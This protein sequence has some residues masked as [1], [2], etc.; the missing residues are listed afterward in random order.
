MMLFICA[1]IIFASIF[2]Q[3]YQQ[4]Q[5]YR[6]DDSVV[7][8]GSSSHRIL[9]EGQYIIQNESPGRRK[10]AYLS[11]QNTFKFA[12]LDKKQV[13]QWELT[14]LPEPH[15]GEFILQN[16]YQSRYFSGY[17]FF[18]QALDHG[19]HACR[20]H[21]DSGSLFIVHPAEEKNEFYIQVV[22]GKRTGHYLSVP[23][24]NSVKVTPETEKTPWHFTLVVKT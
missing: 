17:N 12:A 20:L 9:P 18:I 6:E 4:E 22:S 13:V 7:S 8:T 14:Y 21:P 5:P 10:G 11:Y 19:A 3:E 23:G 16:K 24:R 2:A 15:H 1:T